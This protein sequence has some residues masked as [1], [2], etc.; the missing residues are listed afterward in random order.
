M[1]K[2]FILLVLTFAL[3]NCSSDDDSTTVIQEGTLADLKNWANP[4]IIEAIE[5]QGFIIHEGIN[6]PNIEGSY[7]ISPRVL[8]ATNV[9]NDFP[10]GTT[11]FRINLMFG[12]Q[13]NNSLTVN[14]VGEEL[15]QSGDVHNTQSVEN[16][17]ENSYI[18]GSGNSFT[19]FFKVTE[20]N[21]N[22]NE[23]RILYAF[24]GNIT[25]DGIANIQNALFMLNNFG[26]DGIFIANNTGR[27]FRDSDELA[28]HLVQ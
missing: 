20:V 13:N 24:S 9:S 3:F 16:F 19:V 10:I 8:E 2:Y 18:T 5:N 12:E 4:E 11:F 17:L 25:E 27:I 26:Q 22:G 7:Q 21:G 15:N 6:P 14:F 28:E 1:K 23:A